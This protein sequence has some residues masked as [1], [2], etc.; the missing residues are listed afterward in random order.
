MATK[1]DVRVHLLSVG[2]GAALLLT[3]D[4]VPGVPVMRTRSPARRTLPWMRFP[5]YAALSVRERSDPE[6]AVHC[7]RQSGIRR[8]Q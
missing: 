7:T 8:Q 6:P 4:Q 3:T 1:L 2:F 5:R